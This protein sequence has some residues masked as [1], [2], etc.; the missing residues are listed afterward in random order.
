MA[1]QNL[2]RWV[3]VTAGEEDLER[4]TL[5]ILYWNNQHGWTSCL[6]EAFIVYD[7]EKDMCSLPMGGQ[8]LDITRETS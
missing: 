7:D 2:K 8:W 1:K 3:I 5:E 4:D 6:S